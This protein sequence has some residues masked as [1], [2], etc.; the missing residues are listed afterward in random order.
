MSDRA[1]SKDTTSATSSQASEGGDWLSEWL[2]GQTTGQCGQEAVPASPSPSQDSGREKQTSGTCGPSG[3]TSSASASLQSSL[4]SKLKAR[5]GSA[6]SMLFNE[7]WKQKATPSGWRYLAHTA[8][9][10]R[11]SGSGCGSWPTPA[12]QEPGGTPEAHLARKRAAV[13][14]GVTMGSGAVTSLSHAAQLASWATPNATDGSKGDATLDVV[15]TRIGKRQM[16]TAMQARLASWPTCQKGDGDRGG[17]A[18]RALSGAHAQRLVDF[19]MLA[20]WPTPIVNDVLGSGYCYGP[21]QADGTRAKFLKLP[22]AA[23]LASGPTPTG[24]TAGTEKPGQLNPAH[25]RWLMGYPAAWD[26]CAPSAMRSSRKSRRS[27]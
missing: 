27:S 4:E 9:A 11:T 1:T 20:S 24:S 22:G 6:G 3:S 2:D 21:K 26:D 23:A 7:T 18:Q 5:L 25:S 8:S 15:M 19:A 17:Q 12:A 14:R 10:H 13:A 16:T